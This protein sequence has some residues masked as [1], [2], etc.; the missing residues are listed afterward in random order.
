VGNTDVRTIAS[1]IDK[2]ALAQVQLV[3]F[4]PDLEITAVSAPRTMAVARPLTVS[5]TVRN[6]GTAPVPAGGFRVSFFLAEAA[7]P[8]PAPGDGVGIGF[9]AFTGLAVGASLPTSAV[10][11]VPGNLS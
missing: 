8:P 4:L 6:T 5:F 1:K 3:P 11:N 9:K 10:I 7:T 2:T